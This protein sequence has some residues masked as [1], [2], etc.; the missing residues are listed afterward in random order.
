MINSSES[1][2]PKQS[3]DHAFHKNFEDNSQIFFKTEQESDFETKENTQESRLMKFLN[4]EGVHMGNPWE[5][6]QVDWSG[7]QKRQVFREHKP[8]NDSMEKTSVDCIREVKLKKEQFKLNSRL[9]LKRNKEK[10]K[11]GN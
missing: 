8:Q 6:D 5:K 2:Q 4:D 7:Q 11:N 10:I 1:P 3:P 9:F